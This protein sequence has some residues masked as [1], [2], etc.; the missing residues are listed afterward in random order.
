MLGVL[1]R[2]SSV[3]NGSK[4]DTPLM[5]AYGGKRTLKRAM[6][7]LINRGCACNFVAS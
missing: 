6:T 1:S 2:I 5:R 7:G 3:C 4:A